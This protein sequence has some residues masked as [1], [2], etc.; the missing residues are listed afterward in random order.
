MDMLR[1]VLL[2]L[3]AIY[4]LGLLVNLA[5]VGRLPEPAR[6]HVG[7]LVIYLLAVGGGGYALAEEGTPDFARAAKSLLGPVALWWVHQLWSHRERPNPHTRPKPPG[8]TPPAA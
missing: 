6:Y 4:L 2:A 3:L 5:G 1:F 8:W 7:A